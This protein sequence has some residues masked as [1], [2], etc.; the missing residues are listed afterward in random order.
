MMEGNV[1][2]VPDKRH[3]RPSEIADLC[4]VSVRCVQLW[5]Q[6]EKLAAIQTGPKSR[7]I[8]REAV[9]DFL[10]RMRQAALGD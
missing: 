10:D 6:Q 1:L 7:I 4:G 8:R 3:F 2:T 5:I 9:Q